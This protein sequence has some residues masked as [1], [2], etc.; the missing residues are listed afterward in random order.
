MTFFSFLTWNW[1]LL[2]LSFPDMENNSSCFFAITLLRIQGPAC[3]SFPQQIGTI[4]IYYLCFLT[5]NDFQTMLLGFFI[6]LSYFKLKPAP[7]ER[8]IYL[9][10]NQKH[11]YMC[12]IYIF[13]G[14]VKRLALVIFR[15]SAWE[16]HPLLW[17]LGFLDMASAVP[18]YSSH[19]VCVWSC[20][21]TFEPG[22]LWEQGMLRVSQL[23]DTGFVTNSLLL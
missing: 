1:N 15:C 4:S 12:I 6:A 10:I 19:L 23:A 13:V 22:K 20:W 7:Q 5:R 17:A 9:G 8:F 14:F 11:Y 18:C 21:A 16:N 3:F 2:A